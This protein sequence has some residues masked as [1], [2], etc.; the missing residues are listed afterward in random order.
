MYCECFLQANKD[1]PEYVSVHKKTE[2]FISVKFCALEVLLHQEAILNL[3]AFAQ[4]LQ[5]PEIKPGEAKAADSKTEEAEKTKVAKVAKKSKG[6][7]YTSL[8]NP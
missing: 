7:I 4:S 8:V 5:P 3:L 6:F 1:S 2:Q